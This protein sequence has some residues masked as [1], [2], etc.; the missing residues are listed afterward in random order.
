MSTEPPNPLCYRHPN[1][2]TLISCSNCERPICTECMS[3]AAV[4][5]RCPECRGSTQVRDMRSIGMAG[6]M[7]G[8]YATIAIIAVNVAVFLA[9]LV[10]GGTSLGG[11]GGKIAQNGALAGSYVADGD[12]WRLVTSAFIH[13]GLIHILF[14][15]WAL[16]ALGGS[17]ERYAGTARFVAIYVCSILAGSAGALVADKITGAFSLTAGASGG[18]FG[19]LAALFILERQRGI[20]L[21][22]SQLGL[23]LLL[24]LGLTF[25]VSG[26]SIG[27]HLGGLVG[28]GLAAFALSGYG[29]GHLAYGKLTPLVISGV[30]AVIAASL[31]VSYAVI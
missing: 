3:Q 2:E 27:G 8:M 7:H 24:N 31:V 4:G 14:N 30:A 17:L 28:G 23:I 10:Q 18:V 21:M 22:Q 25:G 11:G 16:Y 20:S 6:G 1:R 19:L 15:M 9:Q 12:W 13:Y 26:I 29:R 5:I